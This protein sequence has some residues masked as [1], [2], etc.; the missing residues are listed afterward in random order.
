MPDDKEDAQNKTMLR[1]ILGEL[2]RDKHLVAIAFILGWSTIAAFVIS[3][4]HDDFWRGCCLG[5]SAM[6]C[7]TNADKFACWFLSVRSSVNVRR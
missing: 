5:A 7:A 2:M 4:I 1:W 3:P 6:L